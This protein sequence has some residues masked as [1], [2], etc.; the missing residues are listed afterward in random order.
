MKKWTLAILFFLSPV[1]FA[2]PEISTSWRPFTPDDHRVSYTE[3]TVEVPL[4]PEAVG[5]LLIVKGTDHLVIPRLLYSHGITRESA[6][7]IVAAASL[8]SID[9]KEVKKILREEDLPLEKRI[10]REGPNRTV[11]FLLQHIDYPWPVGNKWL[12]FRMDDKT[13]LERHTFHRDYRMIAGQLAK[14]EGEWRVVPHPD[15]SGWSLATYSILGDAGF[16]VPHFI[17]KMICTGQIEAVLKWLWKES[18][19]LAKGASH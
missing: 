19:T 5:D 17:A 9:F 1:L 12:L 8:R 14:A 11:S 15:R 7:E 16:Q 4:V 10:Y 3:G 2:A 18:S 13:D 6:K